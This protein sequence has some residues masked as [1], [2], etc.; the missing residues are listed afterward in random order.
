MEEQYAEVREAIYNLAF[1]QHV[2]W[3]MLEDL[4]EIGCLTCDHVWRLVTML[5]VDDVIPMHM[6]DFVCRLYLE[7]TTEYN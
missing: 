3:K 5:E 2:F 4:D 7:I 6:C 1:E